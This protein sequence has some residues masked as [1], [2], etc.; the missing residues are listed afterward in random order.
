MQHLID[1]GSMRFM[2]CP[3]V[4]GAGSSVQPVRA[5]LAFR[6]GEVTKS[7]DP[8]GTQQANACEPTILTNT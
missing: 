7:R 8:S 5:C 3:A 2:R 1:G 6:N 4:W